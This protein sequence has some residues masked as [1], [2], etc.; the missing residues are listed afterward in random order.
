MW[1]FTVLETVYTSH[2]CVKSSVLV[3]MPE[4]VGLSRSDSV[5]VST[6]DTDTWS[7]VA[8]WVECPTT[9]VCEVSMP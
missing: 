9:F 2:L 4:D 1:V 8:W 6:N 5:H 7:T 3:T